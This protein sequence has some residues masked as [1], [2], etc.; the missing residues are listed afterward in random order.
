M[1]AYGSKKFDEK[2]QQ[3]Y[4]E[5]LERGVRRGEAAKACG[6]CYKVVQRHRIAY[7]EFSLL[8]SAAEIAACD[9]MESVI[10]ELAVDK[11]QNGATR[12]KAAITWLQNMNPGKWSDRRQPPII[13]KENSHIIKD[14]LL[15][16]IEKLGQREEPNI[17]NSIEATG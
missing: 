5:H 3:V 10:W 9:I 17:P 15:R 16:E 8:E 6:V 4:L 13:I 2:R 14:D 7:P 12:F 11:E 1:A